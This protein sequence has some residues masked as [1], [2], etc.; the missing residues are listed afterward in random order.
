[1]TMQTSSSSTSKSIPAD[2]SASHAASHRPR[3]TTRRRARP[4]RRT[5]RF[6]VF[7]PVPD[8]PAAPATPAP[9]HSPLTDERS[10]VHSFV[11]TPT[12]APSQPEPPQ[13][14]PHPERREPD[15]SGEYLGPLLPPIIE[16]GSRSSWLARPATLAAA[17]ES[18]RSAERATQ[19]AKPARQG[20]APATRRSRVRLTLRG[21]LAVVAL[22]AGAIAGTSALAGADRPQTIPVAEVQVAAGDTVSSIAAQAAGGRDVAEV[23]AAIQAANGLAGSADAP[24]EPGLVIVVPGSTE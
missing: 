8:A 9:G 5:D 6:G 23:A 2:Q 18:L 12:A 13:R 16:V 7:A 10:M 19:A 3:A 17:R 15:F 1:M 20:A 22:I 21:R 4:E 11:A 14:T 24:L